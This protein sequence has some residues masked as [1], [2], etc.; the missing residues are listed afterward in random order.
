MKPAAAVGGRRHGGRWMNRPNWKKTGGSQ[1][2]DAGAPKT[3]NKKLEATQ[4]SHTPQRPDETKHQ[5][6]ARRK[7]NQNL[8]MKFLRNGWTGVPEREKC[9]ALWTTDGIVEEC[10]KALQVDIFNCQASCGNITTLLR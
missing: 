4:P 3:H 5:G 8:A 1:T 2:V 7:L 10:I 9:F 6:K